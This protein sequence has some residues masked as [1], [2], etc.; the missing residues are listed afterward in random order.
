MLN[1]AIAS[2]ERF[3]CEAVPDGLGSRSALKQA[4]APTT[5]SDDQVGRRKFSGDRPSRPTTESR[6]TTATGVEAPRKRRSESDSKNRSLPSS[7]SRKSPQRKPS[8]DSDEIKE[9]SLPDSKAGL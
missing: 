6:D 3:L 5:A 7:P 8:H 9:A 1:R 4:P 2:G